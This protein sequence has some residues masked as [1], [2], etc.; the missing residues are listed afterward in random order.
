MFWKAKPKPDKLSNWQLVERFKGEV[1][2]ALDA[3]MEGREW[4]YALQRDVVRAL[5]DAA[6]LI[7]M[8]RAMSAPL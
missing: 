8:R 5:R 3:A 4:D 6:Q 2:D 1:R 7:E